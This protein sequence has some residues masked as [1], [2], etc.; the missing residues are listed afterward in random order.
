MKKDVEDFR[1]ITRSMGKKV[2]RKLE[3]DSVSTFL[4]RLENSECYDEIATNA[5]KI[6]QR[7]QNTQNSY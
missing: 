2:I 4:F 7:K 6:P 1:M 5:V 3:L